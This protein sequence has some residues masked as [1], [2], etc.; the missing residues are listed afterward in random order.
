M[1]RITISFQALGLAGNAEVPRVRPAA[2]PFAR[3]IEFVILL[4]AQP[5]LRGSSEIACQTKRHSGADSAFF[6]HQIRNVICWDMEGPR[7]RAPRQSEGIQEFLQE[8]FSGMYRSQFDL[9]YGV[10]RGPGR[11]RR[12][13]ALALIESVGVLRKEL[14][15]YCNALRLHVLLHHVE[16]RR[17]RRHVIALRPVAAVHDA[18]RSEQLP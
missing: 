16:Y 10:G 9:L 14:L 8:D 5:K 17:V 1:A 18:I 12:A 15:R 3:H 2:P 13:P 11:A 4:Q 7:Q 6:I